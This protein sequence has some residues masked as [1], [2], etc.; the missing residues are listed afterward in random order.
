LAEGD[1]GKIVGVVKDFNF[2]SLHST[3]EPLV[4]QYNPRNANYLLV[5]VKGSEMSETISFL[6]N[7]VKT[8]SPNAKFTYTFIDQQLNMLYA[9]ENRMSQVFEGFAVL[10]I[11]ISCLGLFGLSAYS[12]KLRT[13]EVGVRK[14]LGASVAGVTFLLSR[15][16]LVLVLIAIFISLPLGWWA[17]EQ[18]LDTFA[19]RIHVDF[20][21]FAISGLSALLLAM[22]TISFQT[23]KTALL[24]PVKNLSAD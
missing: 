16:F 2:A 24:N 1:T 10:S 12:A 8:L 3:V 23:V 13:K 22:V 4:I 7:Q 19:Y 11:F 18:W 17:V 21:T 20:W 5:K 15:D 14:V 6:E 9:S